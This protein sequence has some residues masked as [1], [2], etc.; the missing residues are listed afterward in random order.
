VDWVGVSDLSPAAFA[1]HL[2]LPGLSRT[3]T[4]PTGNLVQA[5]VTYEPQSGV[6]DRGTGAGTS[7]W[8]DVTLGQELLDQNGA[9]RLALGP[10]AFDAGY[11]ANGNM[12]GRL[13]EGGGQLLGWDAENRL[14]SVTQPDTV[15][16]FV[17]DGDG[18]RVRSVV[19]GTQGVSTTVYVGGYYEWRD[20]ATARSYYYHG[21]QRVAMRDG[22]VTTPWCPTA[23]RRIRTRLKREHPVWHDR[24]AAALALRR[25]S[26]LDE[27]HLPPGRAD[28]EPALLP[29][30]HHPAGAG[31]RAAD[32]L[33]LHRPA[34]GRAVGLDVLWGEVV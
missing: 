15:S 30:G 12:V 2:A 7:D 1:Y 24:F 9:L 18:N 31:E 27:R 14:V 4:Q 20:G 28:G 26:R 23:T 13:V 8:V 11:D 10:E 22:G 17:Y 32:G 6:Y 21:G 34:A 29:L 5:A 25:P 16:T 33:Y 19:T 3:A